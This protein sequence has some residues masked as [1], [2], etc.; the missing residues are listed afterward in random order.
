[1]LR[2]SISVL[3]LFLFVC[4]AIA[5]TLTEGQSLYNNQRYSEALRV[6][7]ALLKKRP[8][9]GAVNYGYGLSALKIGD[10]DE[11]IK[12][13]QIAV[14]KKITS[15]FPLL[16]E[17]YFS[18]YR[19]D[20]TI[21]C[22]EAFLEHPK[23]TFV[24]K[25]KF[26]KL[27][28]KAKIGSQLL[29]RVEAIT[30]IDSLQAPKKD[31]YK[32][33]STGKDLGTIIPSRQIRKNAPEDAYAYRSQRG[34]RVV[35]A[36]SLRHKIGLYGTFQMIDAW[37]DP[38]PLSDR[39]N[40]IGDRINYPFVSSDG[41][42]LYF[43]SQGNNSIGGYDLFITRFNTKENNYF[44]PQNLGFP[45]NSTANDYLMVVDEINNIGWFATDRSQPDGKVMIYKY[46]IN[47]EKK[48]I[49]TEDS[50]YLRLAAQLKC[51][52]KAKNS[53]SNSKNLLESDTQQRKTPSID[54]RINDSTVYRSV[55][56]FVN[57]KAKAYYEEADSI[58]NQLQHLQSDLDQQRSLYAKA[59]SPDEKQK[60]QPEIL[61]LEKE[62]NN[63]CN[64]PQKLMNA[65]R[66]TE[67][68]T[69]KDQQ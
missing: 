20:E 19:F 4:S 55:T 25:N 44:A 9:D 62:F 56:D 46:L 41:V 7:S 58:N 13:L 29:K 1:M 15:A 23:T 31:F 26:S 11:A 52:T 37:S 35:F 2:Y 53:K 14:N 28:E 48:L 57:P 33:Y 18:E 60:I 59:A 63:M 51:Y 69:L 64:K 65:A 39:V 32:Y 54:F 24:E 10:K 8:N 27:L 66:Q 16:A 42:T 6:Y 36:D 50:N 21:T 38:T 68:E 40:T 5:Q 17:L 67:L 43:A 3:I 34:D 22:L 61:R 12:A 49:Q 30:I 47:P 45:F